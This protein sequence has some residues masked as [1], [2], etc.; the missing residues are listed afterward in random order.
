M[1]CGGKKKGKNTPF[2][3]EQMVGLGV[4]GVV[5]LSASKGVSWPSERIPKRLPLYSKS[6]KIKAQRKDE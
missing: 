3:W 5:V 1:K 6:M 2:G 4:E